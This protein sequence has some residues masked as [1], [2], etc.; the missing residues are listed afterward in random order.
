MATPPMCSASHMLAS[1]GTKIISLFMSSIFF[2]GYIIV[3]DCPD[4]NMNWCLYKLV[5]QKIRPR[6]STLIYFQIPVYLWWNV[7]KHETHGCYHITSNL[8]SSESCSTNL[9][10]NSRWQ[11]IFGVIG[12]SSLWH[13][14]WFVEWSSMDTCPGFWIQTLKEWLNDLVYCTTPVLA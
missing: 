8:I 10:P 12:V 1:S 4:L 7:Q 9:D 2:S 5:V 6:F 3:L 11:L 14:I 13:K